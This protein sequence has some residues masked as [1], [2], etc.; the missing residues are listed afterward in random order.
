MENTTRDIEYIGFPLHLFQDAPGETVTSWRISL[1]PSQGRVSSQTQ[2]KLFETAMRTLIE[3]DEDK[4][5][6]HMELE[7]KLSNV[8]GPEFEV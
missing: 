7:Q 2:E 8:I 1:A 5:E 3:G 4:D 6:E